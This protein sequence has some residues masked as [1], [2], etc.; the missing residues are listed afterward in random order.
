MILL[1]HILDLVVTSQKLIEPKCTVLNEKPAKHQT[2][3][4]LL[5]RIGFKTCLSIYSEVK[6]KKDN[7]FPVVILDFCYA[8]YRPEL[9]GKLNNSQTDTS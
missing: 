5:E 1:G 6:V 3:A 8:A 9:P 2:W 7:T 4:H